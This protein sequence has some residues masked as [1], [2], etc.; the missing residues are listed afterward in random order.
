MDGLLTWLIAALVTAGYFGVTA[1]L[2]RVIEPQPARRRGP[3]L[4]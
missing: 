2:A 3:W 4:F 1:L